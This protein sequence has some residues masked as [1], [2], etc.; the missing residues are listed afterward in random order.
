MNLD[1]T[2]MSEYIRARKTV[3]KG[4]ASKEVKEKIP[5]AENRVSINSIELIHAI[6]KDPDIAHKAFCIPV[7][8]DG[9]YRAFIQD[10]SGGGVCLILDMN[11]KYMPIFEN[12][13]EFDIEFEVNKVIHKQS[14][15]VTN[16]TETEDRIIRIG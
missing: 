6:R 8:I 5:R 7:D 2:E 13:E 1:Y 11:Q 9:R 14:L 16:I 12:F 10:F 4:P 15:I 3:K